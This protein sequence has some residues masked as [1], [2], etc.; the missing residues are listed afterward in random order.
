MTSSSERASGSW[1]YRASVA[2]ALLTSFGIVWTT[3][4]RDDGKGMAFFM[5]VMA[6]AIGG[7]SAWFQPAG[8]ART[9]LGVA[10]M[11]VLLGIALATAPSPVSM[12]DASFNAALSSGFYST[13]WLISAGFFRGA[14][15][16]DRRAGT[17]SEA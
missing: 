5:L 9:M 8:M 4:V 12:P 13:L 7:F 6:A 11:Q 14:A 10:V 2:V 1:S 17:L 15:K 16:G 3:V